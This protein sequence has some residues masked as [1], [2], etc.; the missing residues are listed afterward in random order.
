VSPTDASTLARVARAAL[1]SVRRASPGVYA[2]TGGAEVHHVRLGPPE[3]CDCAD[4]L[5]RG[6]RCKHLLAI[7]LRRGEPEVWSALADL[8]RS[9]RLDRSAKGRSR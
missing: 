8:I 1:L 5:C 6:V 3:H 4:R 7:A 9:A 2:V